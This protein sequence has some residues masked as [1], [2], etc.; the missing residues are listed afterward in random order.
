MVSWRA[1]TA[2]PAQA[3]ASTAFC[4]LILALT[5]RPTFTMK[6]NMETRDMTVMLNMMLSCPR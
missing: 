5:K 1:C 6:A 3:A 4:K 2:A